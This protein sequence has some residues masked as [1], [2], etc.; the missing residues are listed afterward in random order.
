MSQNDRILRLAATIPVSVQP[1]V[2]AIDALDDEMT[3]IR[4][5]G[6]LNPTDW[7]YEST[8]ADVLR[9]LHS[10]H[11][12]GVSIIR[13]AEEVEK[14]AVA[15]Q[16]NQLR[17]DARRSLIGSIAYDIALQA[18]GDIV[19]NATA[20]DCANVDRES[21][22]SELCTAYSFSLDSTPPA[23]PGLSNTAA[24]WFDK[25][26][27]VPVELSSIEQA[28]DDS[29][30]DE[31]EE[32]DPEA[33]EDWNVG[34]DEG[35][36]LPT[37][38][39]W[40]HMRRVLER[41]GDEYGTAVT[42]HQ[43]IQ[44]FENGFAG[45]ATLGDAEDKEKI[46]ILLVETIARLVLLCDDEI[47]QELE[48]FNGNKSQIDCCIAPR[49]GAIIDRVD[50]IMNMHDYDD[51]LIDEVSGAEEE[52]RSDTFLDDESG[53][54]VDPAIVDA[55]CDTEV[56]VAELL[57]ASL[58]LLEQF[59]SE[60]V[61]F[62]IRFFNSLIGLGYDRVTPTTLV[63]MYVD[64][65]L[66]TLFAETDYHSSNGMFGDMLKDM[67]AAALENVDA[68]IFRYGTMEE[69]GSVNEHSYRKILD[70]YV[71]AAMDKLVF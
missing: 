8:R 19:D 33:Y 18:I 15:D 64:G 6:Q 10:N 11:P 37:R 45:D 31:N 67:V 27:N 50:D 26:F 17:E 46:R 62:S 12:S 63:T 40:F 36:L 3:G 71:R 5:K 47:A 25:V 44:Y 28:C 59:D 56:D 60:E 16:L 49:V 9:I 42:L 53:N 1:L 38:V 39:P 41:L 51:A 30:I 29:E 55:A 14:P 69:E 35:D 32:D 43:V 66:D 20:G 52:D 4:T 54:R 24:R 7:L 22:A 34:D 58:E 13:F 23:L 68:F 65:M 61:H 21:L 57:D 70:E 48:E 2:D